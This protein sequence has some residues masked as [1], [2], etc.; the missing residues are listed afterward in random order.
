MLSTKWPPFAVLRIGGEACPRATDGWA[1][2]GSKYNEKPEERWIGASMS[3]VA[4]GW[5]LV[6]TDLRS[7]RRRLLRLTLC[8]DLMAET[9]LDEPF[10][11][12][13]SDESMKELIGVTRDSLL[14]YST[15]SWRVDSSPPERSQPNRSPSTPRE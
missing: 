9:V 10:G 7:N 8:G 11:I 3:P 13:G 4:G 2:V 6:A 12:V 14:R 5:I 15:Y 1:I